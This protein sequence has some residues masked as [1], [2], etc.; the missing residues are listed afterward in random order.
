MSRILQLKL[1]ILL[2]LALSL[3][4]CNRSA[5]VVSAPAQPTAA[6]STATA[7]P[8]PTNT[9]TKTSTP[10]PT[11]TPTPTFTPTPI[12]G[13]AC[14]IGQWQVADQAAFLASLGVQGQ[15]LS[16]SGP[17]TYR[18]DADGQA[19]VTVDQFAMKVKAPIKGLPLTVNVLIDGSA[20]ADY[21]ATRSDQL[22]FSNVL[23]DGLTVTVSLGKQELF[24]GTPTEMADT[25]GLSLAP[26]FNAATY[27]CRG[28]VLKYTPPLQNARE[29]QLQRVP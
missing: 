18:F 13:A 10:Q 20:R 3:A 6:L 28:D 22:A 5:P 15:A 4:A 25:F 7:T 16:Q 23:L 2:A 24:S 8:K 9:P 19:Q 11:D 27:A 14:L 26:L 12:S 21:T 29:V 1:F 17:I